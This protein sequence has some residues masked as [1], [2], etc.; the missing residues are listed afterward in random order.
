MGGR[1][2][3]KGLAPPPFAAAPCLLC[4]QAAPTGLLG[5]KSHCG[6]WGLLLVSIVPISTEALSAAAQISPWNQAK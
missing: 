4:M 6:R 3:K 2:G 1:L 5:S